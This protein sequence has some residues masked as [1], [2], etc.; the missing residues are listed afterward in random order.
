MSITTILPAALHFKHLETLIVFATAWPREEPADFVFFAP[1]QAF[2]YVSGKPSLA[3]GT[4]N[5]P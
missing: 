2:P 4:A 5:I 3:T 1:V